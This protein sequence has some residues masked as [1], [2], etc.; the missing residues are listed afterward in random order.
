MPALHTRSWKTGPWIGEA[1]TPSG[2]EMGK[3]RELARLMTVCPDW[4]TLQD[5]DLNESVVKAWL[6]NSFSEWR[7]QQQNPSAMAVT[8]STKQDCF[9]GGGGPL[10]YNCCKHLSCASWSF[11]CL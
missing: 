1:M 8:R 5:L 2:V 11:G 4:I 6:K 7:K 10:T 3:L 9:S